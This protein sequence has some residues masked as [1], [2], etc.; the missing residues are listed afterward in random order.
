VLLA[1]PQGREHALEV[2]TH[3]RN[4][5]MALLQSRRRNAR[6]GAGPTLAQAMVTDALVVRAEA[7]LRW[8]DLCEERLAANPEPAAM[9]TTPKSRGARR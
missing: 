8:L 6:P 5:V 7:D 3:Q 9:T 1:V 4:A 2:I